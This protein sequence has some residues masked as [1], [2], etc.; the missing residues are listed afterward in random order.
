MEASQQL[1]VS[2]VIHAT[3][4]IRG[5]VLRHPEGKP[6]PAFEA[7]AHLD[8][9][10]P[11]ASGEIALRSYSIAS[12]PADRSHY[13]LGVLREDA[14]KGGSAAMHA[15]VGVGRLLTC[16]LPKNHF[17]LA[18]QSPHYL[19]IAG[20]IGITPLLSMVRVLAS[21]KSDFSLYYCVRNG[22]DAAFL[23]EIEHLAGCR[24]TLHCDGGDPSRSVDLDALL[25][26]AP[27]RA[28]VYVCGPR[29]LNEAVI[30]A[31]KR[32]NWPPQRVHFEFFATA[33]PA[34][35]D[36]AF[37]VVLQQSGQT[38][39]VARD[40]SIL[41]ALLRHNVEP[42]YDCK[43]GECGLC[44]TTVIE[45]DVEHRDYVLSPE[46]RNERNLM[47]VCV[48]RSKRGDLILDL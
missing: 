2:K 15:H 42:L 33:A 40:E 46:D 12:S 6:L 22:E 10:I 25:R 36:S 32:A 37:R 9:S 27:P 31:G 45:G 41:D 34:A 8:V 48:S 47:C 20:G 24:L 21:A 38:V 13:L 19:L 5:F 1:V 16:S 11:L 28:D 4:R 43:R 30:E 17:A 3:P 29:G 14:G 23:D 18:P 26:D 35:S 7:G 39:D 44:A